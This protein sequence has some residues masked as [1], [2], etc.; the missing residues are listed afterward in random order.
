ME[1][2]AKE[3]WLRSGSDFIGQ[4]CLRYF[5]DRPVQAKIVS[6]LPAAGSDEEPYWRCRHDD[7]DEEDLDEGEVRVALAAEQSATPVLLQPAPAPSGSSAGSSFRRRR[8]ASASL[9]QAIAMCQHTQRVVAER[10]AQARS[11]A[12]SLLGNRVIVQWN[13]DEAYAGE[14]AEVSDL[15]AAEPTVLVRY[16]DGEQ[17]WESV[18]DPKKFRIIPA[19]A[20][21]L[22]CETCGSSEAL[23]RLHFCLGCDAPHHEGCSMQSVTVAVQRAGSGKATTR[24]NWYCGECTAKQGAC[25]ACRGAHCSHTCLEGPWRICHPRAPKRTTVRQARRRTA[26][27]ATRR[28]LSAYRLPTSPSSTPRARA[29]ARTFPFGGAQSQQE[30]KW[31]AEEDENLRILVERHV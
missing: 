5:D 8:P 11:V 25:T 27:G 21:H 18:E 17:V 29:R 23:A 24:K 3:R 1:T 7:G 15:A 16:D 4:R 26:A 9:V 28:Q 22:A 19:G 6:W 14:V 31:S 30:D 2:P 10:R 13:T 20:T 12:T